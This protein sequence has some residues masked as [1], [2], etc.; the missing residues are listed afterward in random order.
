MSQI[1]P[2]EVTV[3]ERA[4]LSDPE[5][6]ASLYDRYAPRIY[7]YIYHRL[8]DPITAE[9]LTGQTFLRMIEALRSDRGWR[10]SFSGWL[11][12]I[13]HNLVIDHYRRRSQ[14]DF[15]DLDDFPNIPAHDAEADPYKAAAAILDSDALVR[16]INELTE[17]QAQVITLRFLEGYSITEVAVLMDKTEGAI[18]ALQYRAV[19]SLRRLMLGDLV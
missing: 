10:T 15:S 17:E 14:A 3:V 7:S 1:P 5:A 13:A 2:D 4:A 11:F 8:S 18:K 16:A 12:R 19:A 6:I 9:D